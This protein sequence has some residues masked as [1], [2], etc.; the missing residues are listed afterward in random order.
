MSLYHDRLLPRLIDRVMRSGVLSPYRR[1]VAEPAGGR[2]LDIG[3]G[4]GHNLAFYGTDVAE[5]VGLD[6]SAAL[7]ANAA[8]RAP[9]RRPP[10]HLLRA[11]AGCLP[12]AS[13]TFDAALSTWT[14]CSLAD[15]AA[16]LGEI[17]RVLKPGG[18]LHYVEHGRAP[19]RRV[20]RLQDRLTPLWRRLS[21]GCHLNREIDVLIESAGFRLTSR[22][23]GYAPGPRFIAY[24]Y[25]GQ[26]IA[27]GPPA[28]HGAADGSRPRSPASLSS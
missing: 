14:L 1:R 17:R 23:A 15:P 2:I 7:L 28:L 3:I 26:A 11:D 18:A 16:A 10:V 12:F 9:G 6:V 5:V 22:T 4:S 8:D 27:S 25:T 24:F 13:A 20:Q 19:E 21:G